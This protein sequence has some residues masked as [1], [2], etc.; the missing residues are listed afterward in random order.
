MAFA[1]E[2]IPEEH[3][4]RLSIVR[5]EGPAWLTGRHL[6]RRTC[7]LKKGRVDELK[8]KPSSVQF[9]TADKLSIRY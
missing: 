2:C 5:W 9:C 8:G 7:S 6:E 3:H 1:C 4:N